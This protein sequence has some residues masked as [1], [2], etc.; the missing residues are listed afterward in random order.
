M[1]IHAGLT[2]MLTNAVRFANLFFQ[3]VTALD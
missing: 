2:E 1:G 3:I